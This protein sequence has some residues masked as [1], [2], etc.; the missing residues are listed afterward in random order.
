MGQFYKV[1]LTK[2]LFAKKI[3]KETEKQFA[4]TARH[5]G[6][7]LES[8]CP[9]M[10]IEFNKAISSGNNLQ[11]A[12]FS[13]CVYAQTLANMF[14][15]TDFYHYP[16]KP[17]RLPES[18]LRLLTLN[19]LNP[20]YVFASPNGKTALVQ[21]GGNT[22]ID[23]A[24]ISIEAN[25][26]FT[27]EFKEPNAKTSEPDI[28]FAYDESGEL[29]VPHSFINNYPQFS[30][31]LDEQSNLNLNFWD[32]RGTNVK[33]FTTSS[34]EHAVSEN[35]TGTKFADV[36]CVEDKTGALTML[37]ANQLQIWAKT[38]GELR[39]VGRNSL[40]VW[41]PDKLRSDLEACDAKITGNRVEVLVTKAVKAFER[42]SSGTK[43]SR[44]KFG[45][46]FFVRVSDCEIVGAH[47]Y[48]NL[49]DVR[50]TK[51]TISA[52]MNFNKLK[53]SEVVEYY[54]TEL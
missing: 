18:A 19:H 26:I 32:V 1:P 6:L 36:V 34:I 3:R 23:A 39:P 9:A 21:A 5:P 2:V 50:Q 7:D 35:Y 28:P 25:E 4:S 13:E 15:L 52:H 16:G 53:A 11:Q 20:R 29:S 46:V 49:E 47:M 27:I 37:P 43:L 10:H 30:R 40:A 41:T 45:D 33:N 17:A 14:G 51:P 12:I 24:L 22:G 8:L 42:G 48:F 44:Y 31:M 38:K 54:K